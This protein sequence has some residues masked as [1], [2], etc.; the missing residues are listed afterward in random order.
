[1]SALILAAAIASAGPALPGLAP[2]ERHQG[3]NH[4]AVLFVQPEQLATYCGRPADQVRVA[5]A[6][7]HMIIIPNPC[8]V[9]GELYALILCHEL[10]HV[11][12]WSGKH[13]E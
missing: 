12:G 8:R 5:C 10:G 1:M 3:D 2:P 6:A 11:N 13:E 9:V 7:G 4:A